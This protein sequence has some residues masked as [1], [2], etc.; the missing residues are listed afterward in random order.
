LKLL[1]SAKQLYNHRG[2]IRKW[3]NLSFGI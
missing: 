3:R 2:V 1:G